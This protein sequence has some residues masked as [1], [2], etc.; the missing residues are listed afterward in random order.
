MDTDSKAP[1]IYK[2]PETVITS[3]NQVLVNLQNRHTKAKANFDKLIKRI[4]N[5]IDE[6]LYKELIDELRRYKLTQKSFND[7]RV[8]VTDLLA[9]LSKP[10]IELEN[11]FN[12]D[13]EGSMAHRLKQYADEY[14]D[15]KATEEKAKTQLIEK[16]QAKTQEIN[17]VRVNAKL[18]LDTKL[19][20]AKEAVMMQIDGILNS[21]SLDNIDEV[22]ILVMGV[23]IKIPPLVFKDFD[24][25]IDIFHLSPTEVISIFNDAKKSR[26]F[27]NSIIAFDDDL[28]SYQY[29][30]IA[31]IPAI[32][33]ELQKINDASPE[34]E[35]ELIEQRR[36]RQET[37]SRI[38]QNEIKKQ[39]NTIY[40]KAKDAEEI[41]KI[42]TNF[43]TQTE[44][45]VIGSSGIEKKTKW[46]I[47]LDYPSGIAEVCKF[48]ITYDKP[49]D[50]I[51]ANR[52]TVGQMILFAERMANNNGIK[53]E[54]EYVKYSE[55][56]TAKV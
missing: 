2:N 43:E 54:S 53:I 40:E 30:A 16:E 8:P 12:K 32:R 25:S 11:D 6:Q 21:A 13:K 49:Q 7:E 39:K 42:Q 10:F 33:E 44:V 9:D 24:E 14:A 22:K 23:E 20:E 18:Y 5:G 19:L 45:A 35:A 34:E 17:R 47:T 51:K 3:A 37:E 50:E 52:K 4:E 55:V 41:E 29:D 46:K 56:T 27:K 28:V 48:W 26:E 15:K 1:E 36:N 31:K 38:H